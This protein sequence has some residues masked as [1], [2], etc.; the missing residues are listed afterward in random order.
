MPYSKDFK[1]I[2]ALL[3]KAADAKHPQHDPPRPRESDLTSNFYLIFSVQDV[4]EFKQDTQRLIRRL[5]GLCL[6]ASSCVA[7]FV[8]LWLLDVVFRP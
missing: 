3:V 7:A 5:S 8:A 2:S 6:L 1:S 4:V